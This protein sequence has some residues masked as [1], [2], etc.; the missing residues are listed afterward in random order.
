MRTAL[1]AQRAFASAR[2]NFIQTVDRCTLS[3]HDS[4]M[5]NELS[6]SV[7]KAVAAEVRAEI[8]RQH[9]SQA[10]VAQHLRY[11]RP[12]MQRRLY[13]DVPFN[14]TELAAIAELLGVSPA[15]FWPQIEIAA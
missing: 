9:K 3:V 7:A 8:A 13:G 11:S 4:G 6:D 2:E 15:Q 10:S 12:T 5:P 14:V 1:P